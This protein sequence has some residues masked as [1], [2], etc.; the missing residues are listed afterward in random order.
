MDITSAKRRFFQIMSQG[1]TT[2][3]A[4]EL[5]VLIGLKTE[6]ATSAK[7]LETNDPL[8]SRIRRTRR[9]QNEMREK[10]SRFTLALYLGTSG[11]A[12]MLRIRSAIATSE[13]APT[14]FIFRRT[15]FLENQPMSVESS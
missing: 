2:P 10:Q 1:R 8:Y 7:F 13:S 4:G 14:A 3:A 11:G 12:L 9:V 6:M 5:P 15:L